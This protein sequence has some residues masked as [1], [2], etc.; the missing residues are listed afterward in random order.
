MYMHVS[1]FIR[2]TVMKGEKH[3]AK[4]KRKEKREK[5]RT[6]LYLNVLDIRSDSLL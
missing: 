2:K 1:V 5:K 3:N 6:F 4:E